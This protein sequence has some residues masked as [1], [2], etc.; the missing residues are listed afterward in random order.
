MKAD[1]PRIA[2]RLAQV[3]PGRAPAKGK[4][5]GTGKKVKPRHAVRRLCVEPLL[6]SGCLLPGLPGRLQLPI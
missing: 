1:W 5:R 6:V 3:K 2:Q 4:I